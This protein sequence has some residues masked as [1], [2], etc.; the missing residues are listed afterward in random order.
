M[1]NKSKELLPL[2]TPY[3]TMVDIA[4]A[5]SSMVPW[6]GGPVS[7][8]LN[9]IS[10]ERKYERVREVIYKTLDMVKENQSEASRNYV[11]TD[12]FQDL[13]E[14][15]LRRVSDE[16]NEE[17]RLRYARFLARD[18]DEPGV[19]YDEKLRFLKVLEELQ[20]DHIKILNAIT[21]PPPYSGGRAL[22][23]KMYESQPDHLKSLVQQ[24][25]TWGLAELNIM[26]VVTTA[27][28]V[29]KLGKYLTPFCMKFLHYISQ[30]EG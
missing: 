8:A 20:P 17:K 1:N 16:R 23:R 4:A 21:K 3:E 22:L 2:T 6:L 30:P 27:M 15:T 18:I 7:A 25:T 12:D 19:P 5:A 11:K 24:L 13:W 29:Y 14:R 9:G 26:N 10:M 28:G